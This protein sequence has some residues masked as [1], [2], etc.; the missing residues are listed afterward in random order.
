MSPTERSI[1]LLLS[2][3]VF[4]TGFLWSLDALGSVS[5]S[6]FALF[7][8]VDLL[9]FGMIAYIYRISK[10]GELPNRLWFVLGSAML[11]TL[12]FA[13]LFAP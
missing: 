11:L 7:L 5:E 4:S 2:L 10:Q 3:Q 13:S 8:A 1:L 9:A 12:L 6:I